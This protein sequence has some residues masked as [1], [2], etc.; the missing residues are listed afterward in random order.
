MANDYKKSIKN[1]DE[2]YTGALPNVPTVTTT[3]NITGI[4]QE[5]PGIADDI[6]TKGESSY[7]HPGEIQ[8]KH[9]LLKK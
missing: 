9:Y 6:E 2:K 5:T 7:L 3:V 4:P 8:V 1:T